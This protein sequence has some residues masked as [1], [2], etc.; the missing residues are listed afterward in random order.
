MLHT[1]STLVV[2]GLCLGEEDKL[3]PR[4]GH[5]LGL[6]PKEISV[7]IPKVSGRTDDELYRNR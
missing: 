7:R 1:L 4:V 2:H 3:N 5:G 6:K